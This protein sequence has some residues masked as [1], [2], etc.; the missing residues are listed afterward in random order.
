MSADGRVFY[1]SNY[2]PHGGEKRNTVSAGPVAPAPVRRPRPTAAILSTS[3]TKE[4]L[5]VNL[6]TP[7]TV[8]WP[9]HDTAA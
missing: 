6:F 9:V 7:S 4:N 2:N 3:K 1:Y 8:R 5:Y